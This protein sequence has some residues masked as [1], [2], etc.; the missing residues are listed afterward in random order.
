MTMRMTMCMIVYMTIRM[1]VG[2][3]GFVVSFYMA[4]III[5]VNRQHYL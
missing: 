1:A 3:R 2:L 4:I 5:I